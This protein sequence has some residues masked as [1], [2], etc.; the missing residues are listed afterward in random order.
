MISARWTWNTAHLTGRCGVNV[1][2]DKVI[3]YSHEG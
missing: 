1:K 3:D 2:K